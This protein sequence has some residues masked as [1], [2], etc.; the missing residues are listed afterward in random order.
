V[1][2]LSRIKIVPAILFGLSLAGAQSALAANPTDTMDAEQFADYQEMQ[3]S[4]EKGQIVQPSAADETQLASI[5]RTLA[6]E[7][8][9]DYQDSL[10]VQTI[11]NDNQPST[12]D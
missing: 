6:V 4:Q 1:L 8:F 3:L 10:Q 2:N 11:L 9:L 5:A 12:E 7:E